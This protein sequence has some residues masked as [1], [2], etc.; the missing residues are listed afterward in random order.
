MRQVFR[1]WLVGALCAAAVASTGC[2]KVTSCGVSPVDIEELREDVANIDKDLATVQDRQKALEEELATK[3]ADLDSK[4]DKPAELQSQLDLL[5]RGSGRFE[6][7]KT[8]DK[9]DAKKDSKKPA[10]SKDQKGSS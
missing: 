10:A 5:K 1:A 7:K 3:Q 2:S 9:K 6:K 4:K 8:T